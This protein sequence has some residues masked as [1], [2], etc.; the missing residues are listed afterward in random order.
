MKNIVR[1]FCAAVACAVIGCVMSLNV[2][3]A[4]TAYE[5]KELNMSVPVPN[6]MLV[7]TR[8]TTKSDSFFSEFGLDYDETMENL[9]SGNIYLQ[10]VKDD[11]LLTLTVTMTKT[12]ESEKI[13][14]YS[15]LSE[16]ELTNIKEA[17]LKDKSYKSA[18]FVESKGVKYINL[19]MSYKVDDKTVKAQQYNTVINGE[20][21]NITLQSAPDSKLTKADKETLAGIISET[22][23]LSENFFS[24]NKDLLI[25]GGVTLI[26]IILVVVVIIVVVRFRK[27]P[28]RRHHNLVHEMAH[29]RRIS[30][31]TQIPR[32]RVNPA[33]EQT[34]SFLTNYEPLEEIDKPKKREKARV[35]A[36]KAEQAKVFS[37]PVIEE[38]AVEA[39]IADVEVEETASEATEVPETVEAVEAFPNMDE[40]FD[41]PLEEDTA[42]VEETAVPVI[43]ETAEPEKAE[44]AEITAEAE[45]AAETVEA[46]QPATV[47]QSFESVDGVEVFDGGFEESSDYFDEGPDNEENYVFDH[48]YDEEDEVEADEYVSERRSRQK[49]PAEIGKKVKKVLAAIGRVL[50]AIGKG[51][52]I[53]FKYFFLGIWYVITHIRYFCINLYRMIKRNR[54]KKKRIKAEQQ[55]RREASERRRVQREAE[56]AR[57]QRNAQRRDSNDLIKVRSS[58]DRRPSGSSQTVRRS[59]SSGSRTAYP[60]RNGSAARRR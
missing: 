47:A 58:G 51:I 38:A 2:F 37:E 21:I 54:A 14:S 60:S 24:K 40:V 42:T 52:L 59:G 33:A 4:N 32:P 26:G 30:E 29:E 41:S 18:S 7:L 6:D 19:S 43:E 56:R 8:E 39:A 15:S 20:N 1:I 57:Q 11:S 36:E 22:T 27:N 12:D 17:L 49:N 9:T 13:G 48:E 25:Y 46:V 44:E 16:V 23:I 28:K 45:E 34:Q 35:A 55:R 31:T 53:A 10:A 50:L 5:I 3:A